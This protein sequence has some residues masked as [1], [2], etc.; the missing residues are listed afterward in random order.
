[1]LLTDYISRIIIVSRRLNRLARIERLSSRLAEGGR[2]LADE[3]DVHA[4][5]R[6][7]LLPA[8]LPLTSAG[9]WETSP[10]GRPTAD[11]KRD[12]SIS[13]EIGGARSA[14]LGGSR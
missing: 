13:A 12:R 8:R 14:R 11:E 3:G 9:A 5:A 10:A 6:R 7:D 1:V 2:L 4:P